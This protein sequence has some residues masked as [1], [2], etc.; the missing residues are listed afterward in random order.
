MCKIGG[1]GLT[2]MTSSAKEGGDFGQKCEEMDELGK[3]RRQ[4]WGEE[5]RTFC[6]LA[7]FAKEFHI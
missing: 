7:L 4:A 2:C 5:G 6:F 1:I 3:A